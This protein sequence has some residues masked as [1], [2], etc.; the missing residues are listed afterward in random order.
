MARALRENWNRGLE[1][2]CPAE[3]FM[4]SETEIFYL[5]LLIFLTLIV[6]FILTNIGPR[7]DGKNH[8]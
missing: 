8:R 6:H 4:A 3:A 7:R 1:V 5:V 2:L